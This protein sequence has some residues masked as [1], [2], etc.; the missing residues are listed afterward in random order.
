MLSMRC[1]PMQGR[2]ARHFDLRFATG[3]AESVVLSAF[4]FTWRFFAAAG[5]V[6]LGAALNGPLLAIDAPAAEFFEKQV[7]PVLAARFR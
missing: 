7:R 5:A 6:W 3:Y 4:R 2:G 1:S